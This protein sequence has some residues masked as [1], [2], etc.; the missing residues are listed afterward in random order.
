MNAHSPQ[1]TPRGR[2]R[3][4][5]AE[6]PAPSGPRPT[7]VVAGWHRPHP[8]RAGF[9]I[10]SALLLVGTLLQPAAA[11]HTVTNEGSYDGPPNFYFHGNAAQTDNSNMSLWV[12][13]K[14]TGYRYRVNARAGS[15]T[16]STNDCYSD[17]GWLP[18]GTYGRGDNDPISRVEHQYKTGGDPVVR[19]NV[20]FLDSKWCSTGSTKRWGLFIHS[21]GIEGTAWDNN[22]KTQGCIK[23]SQHARDGYTYYARDL[24]VDRNNERL[25]VYH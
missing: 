4:R 11:D 22:W 20:W 5:L 18:A 13:S 25:I 19:G 6:Q 9:T 8:L 16:G 24:A 7:G 23:V 10:I 2:P 17:N 3:Q 15:G 21:S 14:N 12:T 1:S